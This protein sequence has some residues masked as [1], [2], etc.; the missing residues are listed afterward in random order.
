MLGIRPDFD[1]LTIA[2]CIPADWKE[3]EVSRVWR[4]ARFDIHVDNSEGRMKSVK[5]IRLDGVTVTQIP[6]Q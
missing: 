6:A 4:D 1:S 3:Y 2:P 5:E